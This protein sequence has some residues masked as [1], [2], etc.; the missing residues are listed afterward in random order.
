MRPPIIYDRINSKS[1]ERYFFNIVDK[2]TEIR[3]EKILA[4]K[5]LQLKKLGQMIVGIHLVLTLS[6]L[7][8]MKV[9]DI[10]IDLSQFNESVLDHVAHNKRECT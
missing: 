5:R 4:E 1:P 9:I 2:S 3:M 7:F 10:G 6:L 8:A